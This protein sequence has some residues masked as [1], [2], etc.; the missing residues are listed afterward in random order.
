MPK[1]GGRSN[2]LVPRSLLCAVFTDAIDLCYLTVQGPGPFL[3]FRVFI[4]WL[5]K[6]TDCLTGQWNHPSLCLMQCLRKRV[7]KGCCHYTTAART[8]SAIVT[9]RMR[10]LLWISCLWISVVV[11]MLPFA[12]SAAHE[13]LSVT[14]CP[15]LVPIHANSAVP[16][17]PP[18]SSPCP[19]PRRN[20]HLACE[21]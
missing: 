21:Q 9:H 11:G 1:R 12:H 16:P 2:W 7:P 3:A 17:P 18:L 10:L 15:L 19:S 6:A 5:E 14:N 20:R 8:H 13:P 4:S